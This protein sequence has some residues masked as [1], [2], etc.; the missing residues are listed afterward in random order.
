MASNSLPSGNSL[1]AP[2]TETSGQC[3]G[4]PELWKRR[5]FISVSRLLRMA[6]LALN[7]SSTKAKCASGSLPLVTRWKLSCSSALRLMGPNNSSGVEKRVSRCSKYVPPS[8]CASAR[9][10]ALLAV[11]GGPSRRMCSEARMAQRAPSMTGL[12]SGKVDWRWVR[13]D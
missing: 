2:K 5:S 6:L 4:A 12:R 10:S 11:P 9:T 13:M 7:T 1:L 3:R 8:A